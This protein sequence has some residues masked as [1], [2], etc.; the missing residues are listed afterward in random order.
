MLHFKTQLFVLCGF[1]FATSNPSACNFSSLF[2]IRQQLDPI[3]QS[4][5][6]FIVLRNYCCYLLIGIKWGDS[7]NLNRIT[8]PANVKMTTHQILLED[9][10]RQNI[11][12][13]FYLQNAI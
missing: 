12:K 3:A 6:R 4:A 10:I 5:D 11:I 7:I 9:T 2:V 13:L 8:E 1:F